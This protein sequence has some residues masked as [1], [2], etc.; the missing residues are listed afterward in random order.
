MLLLPCRNL[1][2]IN[3]GVAV[4]QLR[5]RFLSH[6]HGGDDLDSVHELQHLHVPT[7]G[8]ANSLLSVPRWKLL[9]EHWPLSGYYLQRGY[10]LSVVIQRVHELRRHY[11]PG[12]HWSDELRELQCWVLLHDSWNVRRNSMPRRKFLRNVGSEFSVWS[13]LGWVVFR[14][15]SNGLLAVFGRYFSGKLWVD[16]LLELCCGNV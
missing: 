2:A 13:V 6:E 11:L 12:E 14:G 9:R 3:W 4:Q 16:E 10:L 5:G 8:S 15:S 7:I 1:R